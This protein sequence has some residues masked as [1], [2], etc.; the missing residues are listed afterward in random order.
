MLKKKYNFWKTITENIA[1][2]RNSIA[3]YCGL[4]CFT[5]EGMMLISDV[6]FSKFFNF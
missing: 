5:S 1:K 6:E 4:V 3:D 2:R